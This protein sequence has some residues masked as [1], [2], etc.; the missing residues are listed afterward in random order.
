MS[1]DLKNNLKKTAL[2]HTHLKHQAKMVDFAG[3]DMPIHYG[4]QMDEHHAVRNHAGIFDVSHMVVS[5]LSGPDVK[6]FLSILVSNDVSK[7]SPHKALYTCLL[8]PEGGVIDD[9]IIYQINPQDFRLV[10]NAGTR[11]KDLAWIKKQAESFQFNLKIKHRDDL[12]ILALQGPQ[13]VSIFSK[14]FPED[15]EDLNNLSSF[16][17]KFKNTWMLARTGY[18]GEDGLEIILPNSDAE[19]LWEQLIQAGVKPCGLGARDTLRL[20]AGMNLYGLDMDES[21]SPLECGLSW[22]VDLK[23]SSRN[24]I[25]RES[26][27]LKKSEQINKPFWTQVGLILEDKGVM[28]SHQK[29]YVN[30]SQAISDQIISGEITSGSF[31]PTLNIS[32]GLARVSPEIK[33]Q[34]YCF[35]EIR[36]KL[37]K[38]KIVKL[39]F[40]A[41]KNS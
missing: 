21:I 25:G 12:S 24:F 4:S 41:K 22:T 20:E 8:N 7:L 29:I 35:V 37:L 17:F 5:D 38:A 28:R 27:E 2:Y 15:L 19:F 11:E 32:I 13:A 6:N 31:S 16:S 36:N 26:L 3:F 10:T 14:I 39:P 9:L 40:V 34:G 33:Q 23:N 18:T 30:N 1:Q